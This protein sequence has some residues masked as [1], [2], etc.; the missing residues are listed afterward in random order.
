MSLFFEVHNLT[1]EIEQA[2]FTVFAPTDA[3]IKDYLKRTSAAALVRG[4]QRPLEPP[5]WGGDHV[6]LL[7]SITETEQA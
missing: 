5:S 2:D 1:E 3:A 7:L 6:T 4:R